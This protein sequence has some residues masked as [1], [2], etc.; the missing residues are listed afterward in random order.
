M[1]TT[2]GVATGFGVATGALATGA[3]TTLPVG[4]SMSTD[5]QATMQFQLYTFQVDF[6]YQQQ[7]GRQVV[8]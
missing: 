5:L 7:T 8:L 4:D 3:F 1:A 2:S 6:L